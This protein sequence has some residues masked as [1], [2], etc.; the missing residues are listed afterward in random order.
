M[1]QGR[2]RDGESNSS[3]PLEYQTL[4]ELVNETRM[5]F[6]IE[7]SLGNVSGCLRM[8]QPAGAL[9]ATVDLVQYITHMPMAT[10]ALQGY[11]FARIRK[12][13]E[14]FV[15]QCGD[16]GAST[17]ELVQ[18][19][20]QLE[21][22]SLVAPDEDMSYCQHD[23]HEPSDAM[24]SDSDDPVECVHCGSVISCRRMDMHVQYWCQALH[25]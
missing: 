2:S 24:E 10:K 16:E 20:S 19:L 21:G 7:Q 18:V 13:I 4:Q 5:D 9:K 22:M 11:V 14:L 23:P 6:I 25:R 3:R 15:E 1:E 12:E 17:S 8:H